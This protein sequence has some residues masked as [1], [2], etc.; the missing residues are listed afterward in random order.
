MANKKADSL[1]KFLYSLA[2]IRFLRDRA[3]RSASFIEYVV[4]SCSQ[5]D[6]MLRVG[7]I[8]KEQIKN[9]T[10]QV[11]DKWLVKNFKERDIFNKSKELR[12]INSS[13]L[14]KL[15]YLYD[16]RNVVVHRF[17]I[18]D[19]EYEYSKRLASEFEPSIVELNDIL[20]KIEE[21]QIAKKVGITVSGKKVPL[22]KQNREI[23]KLDEFFMKKMGND[24]E[25]I[26]SVRGHKWPDVEDIIEF[27][28]RKGYTKECKNCKHIRALH[29]KNEETTG[30]IDCEC[31]SK[32][33]DCASFK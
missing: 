5:I 29:I 17:V 9:K 13:F 22:E 21:D 31:Q 14:K 24:L 2:V 32:G 3:W 11:N 28:S 26:N 4:L 33:C 18:T 16:G 10:N 8:L 20:Y 7:I 15:N 19:V 23:K 1:E 30:I 12:I 27:A 25:K 6:A